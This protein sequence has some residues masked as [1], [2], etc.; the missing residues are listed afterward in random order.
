M[1]RIVISYVEISETTG[2][3]IPKKTWIFAHDGEVLTTIADLRERGHVIRFESKTKF[4]F[5][6]A[7]LSADVDMVW[8]HL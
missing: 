8:E 3:I 7:I 6:S 2:D 5:P 1:K 4:I